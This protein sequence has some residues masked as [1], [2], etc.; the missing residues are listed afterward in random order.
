MTKEKSELEKKTEIVVINGNPEFAKGISQ[1]LTDNGYCTYHYDD[2]NKAFDKVSELENPYIVSG[3]FYNEGMILADFVEKLRE[4]NPKLLKNILILSKHGDRD[5][6]KIKS[7]HGIPRD[8]V[9]GDSNYS[10]KNLLNKLKEL[11]SI[12]Q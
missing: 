10:E 3:G 8:N 12:G 6:D 4:Y 11:V 5:A 7:W 9:F 2:C 1:L